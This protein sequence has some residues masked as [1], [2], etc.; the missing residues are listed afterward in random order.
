MVSLD[1]DIEHKFPSGNPMTRLEHGQG[2]A[3]RGKRWDGRGN[4]EE[5][6][7]PY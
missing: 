6:Y 3:E 1:P 5:W 2:R 7:R 4:S